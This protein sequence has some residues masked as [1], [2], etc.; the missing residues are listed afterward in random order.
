MSPHGI[1]DQLARLQRRGVER[2]VAGVE[3]GQ[4]EQVVDQIGEPAA[5][6]VDDGEVLTQLLG[7][8]RVAHHQLGVP[9]D[10]PDG[11]AARG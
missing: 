6:A 9:A 4:V 1:V 2:V 7:K 8:I 5:G 3:L 10:D 11:V